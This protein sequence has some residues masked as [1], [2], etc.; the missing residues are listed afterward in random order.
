MRPSSRPRSARLPPLPTP[1]LATASSVRLGLIAD[2]HVF[3]NGARVLSPHVLAYFARAK[4]DLILHA[5][6]VCH[7]G[8]LGDLAA[9]APVV[10]VRGNNDSGDFGETLPLVYKTTIASK[11]LCLLHGHIIDS[12]A[13][14]SAARMAPDA[15]VVV[16]GHSH[17]PMLERVDDALLVNPGSPTDKRFEPHF[18][19]ALLDISPN[20]IW[21]ELI[22]FNRASDLDHATVPEKQPM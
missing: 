17:V 19:I 8:V 20:R 12:S 10:A 2:T 5:G 18:G 7:Q 3:P 15:D 4:P 21:P 6:D 13:R 22:L 16:Y 9:I 14:K 1:D 11:R